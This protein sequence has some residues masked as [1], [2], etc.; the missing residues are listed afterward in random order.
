MGEKGA[1]G[2]LPRQKIVMLLFLGILMI[3]FKFIFI[4]FSSVEINEFAP[5]SKTNIIQ[6][7]LLSY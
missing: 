1:N 2:M 5:V 6:I 4:F 3:K 7:L